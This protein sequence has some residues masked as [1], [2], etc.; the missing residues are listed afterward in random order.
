MKGLVRVSWTQFD[1]L[2]RFKLAAVEIAFRLALGHARDTFVTMWS[3]FS[4]NNVSPTHHF[5]DIEQIASC[6]ATVSWHCNFGPSSYLLIVALK[7]EHCEH[8]R[9]WLSGAPV[10]PLH[11]AFAEGLDPI[12]TGVCSHPLVPPSV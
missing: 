8:L 1:P 5:G 3:D 4:H 2:D 7:R 6:P 9:H 11:L 10:A 12:A